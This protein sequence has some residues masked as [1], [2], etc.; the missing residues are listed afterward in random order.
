MN[1]NHVRGVRDGIVTGTARPIHLGRTSHV[2]GIEIR[3]DA[4]KLVCVARLTA[5]VIP[6]GAT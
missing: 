5:T 1:A 2:W 3:S 4:G 6:L